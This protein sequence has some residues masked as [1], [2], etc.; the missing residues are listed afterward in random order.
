MNCEKF[1]EMI[2]DL[3]REDASADAVI[4]EAFSHAEECPECDAQ[5]R[6]AERL[7]ARLHT[8]ATQ[9]RFDEAPARV[10][11]A[12]TQAFRQQRVPAPRLHIFSR[13]LAISTAALASAAVLVILATGYRYG[14]APAPTRS[15]ES[16]PRQSNRPVTTPRATWAD[17]A[18]DG[19]SEE[20]AAAAYI[21]LSADFD[22]SWLEG[23]AIVRVALSRSALESMGV[24]ATGVGD[25]QM[26]ADMVVSDDGTPQAIRIVDWE[27]PNV[28]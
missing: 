11:A 17:Y 21:P 8:L 4:T 15:P 14:A 16:A 20:Q 26:I 2:H 22:P 12:L 6:D 10:E 27:Q 23:G 25:E 19:E 3:A 7:T 5:L 13:W 9:H 24:P 28:Q 18:V 1:R